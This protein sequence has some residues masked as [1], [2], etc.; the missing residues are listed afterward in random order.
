MRAPALAVVDTSLAAVLEPTTPV[1]TLL[2]CM[3][4]RSHASFAIVTRADRIIDSCRHPSTRGKEP[5]LQTCLH[6]SIC[7]VHSHGTQEVSSPS[8]PLLVHP[9]L[10]QPNSL[11]RAPPA[12]LTMVVLG[13]EFAASDSCLAL[14]RCCG[15]ARFRSS[16]RPS[17]R[18]R[19][20]SWLSC[21]S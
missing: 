3:R 14:S 21:C 7:T 5:R 15:V 11:C 20:N 19:R 18:K 16:D 13:C 9:L 2:L 6:P 1:M 12:R 8:L 17:R 10:H 4:K